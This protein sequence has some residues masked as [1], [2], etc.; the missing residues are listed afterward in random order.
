MWGIAAHRVVETSLGYFINP[1][2]NVLL[3]VV[4]PVGAAERRAVDGGRDRRGGRRLA[5][6]DAPGTRRGSR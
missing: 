6:L 2:V 4:A 5:D 1:L 3:G